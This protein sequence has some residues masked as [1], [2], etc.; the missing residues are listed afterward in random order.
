[1][2][3]LEQSCNDIHAPISC[4]VLL[5]MGYIVAPVYY[6]LAGTKPNEGAVI[7]CDRN[8]LVNL[9]QLNVSSSVPDTW[10]LLETNYVCEFL[11]FVLCVYKC[12]WRGLDST[13]K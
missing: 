9:W 5:S 10:Y 4:S 11:C 7:T 13:V 2:H 6:I 8:I 12:A 1:M 3:K